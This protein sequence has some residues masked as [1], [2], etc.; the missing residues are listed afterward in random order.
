MIWGIM[1]GISVELSVR[2]NNIICTITFSKKSSHITN[3]YK[4]LN[5]LKLN[6]IYKLE[7]AKFMYNLHHGTLPKSLYD[8]FIKLSAIH[9]Y[10]TIQKQNLVYF[11]PQIKKAIGREMLTHRGSNL[12]KE[13][14]LFIKNL[15]WFF[16]KTHYKKFL[17]EK[18]NSA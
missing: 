1:I 2:L 3:H 6:D 9:N 14:K 16:F 17:I 10:S 5:L 4:N 13:I 12:W 15:G 7:L 8:L 18:Y 11:N